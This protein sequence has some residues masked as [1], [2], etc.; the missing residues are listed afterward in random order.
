M[1]YHAKL[2][3]KDFAEFTGLSESTLRYYDR[4]GLLS[5]QLRGKNRYR[6]YSPIQTITVDFIKV[7]IKVGVPLTTI[8]ELHK[9]R[10]PQSVLALLKQQETILDERLRDLHTAYT[11]I[12]TYSDNIEDGIATH[13][14]AV[15]VRELRKANINLGQLADY[16]NAENVYEPFIQFCN[17]AHA[18][19]IDLL[20]P[21]GSYYE[22]I[23]A[24]IKAPS[25]PTRLFS[26]DPRGN[27][28]RKAGKYLVAYSKGYYGNYGDLPQRLRAYAREHGLSCKGPVYISFLLDEVSTADHNQYLAQIVVGVSKSR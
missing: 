14:D 16:S 1:D 17:M 11:I 27:N 9:T 26:Q 7:L 6:Y 28:Y 8:K 5:P 19:R 20:Y 24:F 13:E 22:D 15:C 18:N 23:H 25:L 2:S 10:T 21:I 4:I 3:I 12:H